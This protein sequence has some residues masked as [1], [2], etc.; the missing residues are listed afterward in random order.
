M[1]TAALA[2]DDVSRHFSTADG[3]VK[4]VDGISLSIE[5]GEVVAFLGPNG[6]G[7]TTTIDMA[8]GLSEPT[9]GSITVFGATPRAAVRAGRVSAVMQTGGLLR[10]L[11][12]HETVTSIAALQGRLDRVD[13]VIDQADLGPLRRRLVA[14][15]SGGEKQRIKFALALITEPD[16]L[17]LDE[18]TAGMDV[19]ARRRFW[20]SMHHQ[21]TDGR[22]ILFA[23]HYL[24]E[25]EQFAQRIVLI[26]RGRLLAD[27]PTHEMR[28]LVSS[29][30]VSAILPDAAAALERL[31]DVEG[32]A[33]IDRDG[34]RIVAHSS[35]S[36]DLARAMLDLGGHDLT[37]TDP[38][39][40]DAFVSL[41]SGAE[42]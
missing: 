24:E 32:T 28:S 9:A 1:S 2:L 10:D 4:A 23:T 41:T 6:A 20:R 31:R 8:L 35:R 19:T 3:L 21:A 30:Q 11:T 22:T 42:R 39:L 33:K 18:P 29:R 7:K 15:C 27:G 34:D 16:L 14:K 25:A 5:P 13:A 40:E 12:V 38:S 17:I 37:I 26:A 36:D